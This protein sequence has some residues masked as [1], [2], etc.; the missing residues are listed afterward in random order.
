MGTPHFVLG[1]EVEVRSIENGFRGSWYPATIFQTP[2]KL[3]GPES[4][5]VEIEYA[6]LLDPE[7]ASKLLR[8]IALICNLRPKPPDMSNESFRLGEE[9]DV[10]H[11]D[12]WW[13]GVVTKFLKKEMYTVCLDSTGE[14]I[15][16][17]MLELRSHLGWVDGSWIGADGQV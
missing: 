12:G 1:Q 2:L 4:N 10:Y 7:R 13:K 14:E 9:V 15:D 17:G 16:F 5:Q 3:S 11:N 8:E 6:S